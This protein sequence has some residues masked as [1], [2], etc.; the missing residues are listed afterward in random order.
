MW[1]FGSDNFGDL[2]K[3]LNKANASLVDVLTCYS[4]RTA[5][6]QTHMKLLQ[7]LFQNLMEL[8][9]MAL[10]NV[11]EN[12]NQYPRQLQQDAMFCMITPAGQFTSQ[13]TTCRPFL[14]KLNRYVSAEEP[15]TNDQITRFSAILEFIVHGSNGFVL[16]H[17][18]DRNNLLGKLLK[19][20]KY[21]SVFNLLHFLTYSG[22]QI[23]GD[24]L[25]QVDA[26]R[27]LMGRLGNDSL[28]N[29]RLFILMSNLV[30]IAKPRS[31]LTEPF[32][33]PEAIENLL[34]YC[35]S[36]NEKVAAAALRLLTCLCNHFYETGTDSALI[37]QIGDH[38]N[39][40]CE[41]IQKGGRFTKSRSL[42]LLILIRIVAFTRDLDVEKVLNLLPVLLDQLVAKPAFTAVHGA[43]YELL[44][45]GV[46]RR[47]EIVGQL[48]LKEKIMELYKKRDNLIACYWGYLH[49][50]TGLIVRW[51]VFD[52]YHVDGW[53]KFVEDVYHTDEQLYLSHYGG[54]LPGAQIDEDLSAWPPK[55]GNAPSSGGQI[56]SKP[57]FTTVHLSQPGATKKEEKTEEED[58]FDD[59]EPEPPAIQGEEIKWVFTKLIANERIKNVVDLDLK[60]VFVMENPVDSI[61]FSPNGEIIAIACGN[62]LEVYRNNQYQALLVKAYLKT[63][64]AAMCFTQDNSQLVLICENDPRI[65]YYDVES[66][67]VKKVV[68]FKEC[69]SAAFSTDCT[70][71]ACN[72]DAQTSVYNLE[73]LE[74]ITWFSYDKKIPMFSV[75]SP[76]GKYIATAYVGGHAQIYALE[77]KTTKCHLK[78]HDKEITSIVVCDSGTK[79]A[80]AS[81]DSTIKLWSVLSDTFN[82]R[83]MKGHKQMINSISLDAS[84]KWIIS[85]S[86]DSTFN[87]TSVTEEEMVYSVAA[88]LGS[89]TCIACDPAR[90]VFA[91][92]SEDQLV[93]IWSIATTPVQ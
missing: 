57:Q 84:Q 75:F 9:D 44:K 68:D 6:G 43:F 74:R 67:G 22:L 29:E 85:G 76:N 42:A 78:C 83:T 10:G 8:T 26:M 7:F 39:E 77:R 72:K 87:I 3:L 23:V 13:L 38:I 54:A 4:F 93:K 91:T 20:L 16:I 79:F 28:E 41:Y 37:R 51:R 47:P 31:K 86:K 58:M 90:P 46:T 5:F 49:R 65:L 80:T 73:T 21:V 27:L 33:N 32:L 14:Q 2:T 63:R 34:K 19:Y 71:I 1:G 35:F 53:D 89:L 56:L 70:K 12:G 62:D 11:D 64:I 92:A 40:F 82:W 24:Y 81:N 66:G 61:V 25:L 45:V 30:C 59:T 36:E 55:A 69:D 50:I 18:P 48:K 17:F 15:L 60:A 52:T 88:H